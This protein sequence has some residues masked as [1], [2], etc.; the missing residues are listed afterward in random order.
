MKIVKSISVAVLALLSV[1][2]VAQPSSNL[3][4]IKFEK[5]KLPNGLEVLLSEDHRLPLV[6]VNL[7]YHVGAAN[8]AAGR[9]G[10][11]HL[12]EHMMFEGSKHVG[13]KAH[14]KY[15]EAAGAP[16]T[17]ASTELDRTNY[18]ETLP[19]NQLEL[20]LW[21]ESDRMGYL[22]DTVD[23]EK[24][25]NQRD[26]VRNER[27][28]AIENAPYGLADEEVY[29]QLFP[30]LHPYYAYVI[31][32]HEDVEAARLD[33]VRQFF[34]TYYSPNNASMAIVGDF[35]P[36]QVKKLVEKYFGSI[37][38]GPDVPPVTVETPTIEKERR[39]TV[40]DQIELPRVYMAWFSPPIFKPG[41]AD[42]DLLAEILGGG[43]SSR[44][45]QSLVYEKQIAQDVNVSNQSLLLR[46]V[47]SVQAT[48]KPGVKL[49][50]LEKAIDA[51]IEEVRAKGLSEV[52]IARARN[53][54]QSRMIRRLEVL[55]GTGGVAD[56]LNRYNHYLRDPGFLPKDLERYDN[57][58]AKSANKLAKEMLASNS[59]VV[60]YAVPGKKII[61]DVA[62]TKD[63]DD[64]KTS[65]VAQDPRPD[66][67]W[68]KEAPKAGPPSKLTLPTPTS[69]KLSNGLTVML[70]EQH[71]LPVV[72]ANLVTLS[73][74][75]ANPINKPGLAAFTADMLLEG[76]RDRSALNIAN[77]ADQ[78]GA[79]LD[80]GSTSDFS[81]VTI[82]SLKRTAEFAFNLLSD[83]VLHPRFDPK[84][85]ERVRNHR[86]TEIVQEKDD[87]TTLAR[88]MSYMALYGPKHPYGYLESG[89][90]PATKA[91][92][93]ED[94]GSFWRAG[95]VPGNS[96]LVLAGDLD[97]VAAKNLAER[98]FGTWTGSATKHVPPK[99]LSTAKRSILVLDKPDAPQTAI[100]F[101]TVAA[102]RSTKDYVPLEVMNYAFGG[103][104]SSRLN[105]NLREQHGF[106][107]GAFS[108]VLYRRAPGPFIST[109][110]V[111]TDAT[112]AAVKEVFSELRRI[113]DSD[114]TPE[115]LTASKTAF[116]Q[117]LAGRFE[118]TAQTA[119]TMAEL[120]VYDLPLNY[121]S[122]LPQNIAAV[123][124]ADVRRVAQTYLRPDTMVVVAVG[125]RAKIEPELKQ[126]QVAPVLL[127]DYEGREVRRQSGQGK[128][129]KTVAPTK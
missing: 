24:L 11:A 84:E 1:A 107:Y 2:A 66:E 82:R 41:D 28:E 43:K 87:P 71:N 16:D 94:L 64:Q 35:D 79:A 119:A 4:Q 39:V 67:A 98:Y 61:H 60:V 115:E 99:V 51:E 47:F 122:T 103:L 89:T 10:F 125:D 52:E 111:R 120:F 86:L 73:G 70:V 48:A 65:T 127:R 85:I 7:W 12:F 22:L 110:N 19:S 14:I 81:V 124:A 72:T 56:T 129:V 114:I 102:P 93:R 33:D 30:K 95:Y 38:A 59:R 32:S 123:R 117:S 109:A 50:D 13:P 26:V 25:A 76:T 37:P 97:Q 80:S 9:T 17:N 27:R 20:A 90:E 36:V 69:F 106:T 83:V 23:H 21:L 15:L 5:Y 42:A 91:I 105:M 68:R 116:A 108:A 40:T 92:T 58:S 49:E 113:R 112:G 31:G 54:Q 118:T 74:S 29:H 78:I 53:K 3:P 128:T 121:Y 100:R 46:S 104:F 126:L 44:L 6:A 101:A 18:Y 8:E 96:V 34:K 77:D 88:K 62:K 75:E 57:V 63:A 45:Y 55:G